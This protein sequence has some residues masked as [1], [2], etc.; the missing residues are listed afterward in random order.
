M[1]LL[2]Q[3][4]SLR[5]QNIMRP[6]VQHRQDAIT[7]QWTCRNKLCVTFTANPFLLRK[8]LKDEWGF[9]GFVVTDYTAIN[10]MVK[11]GFSADEKQAGEQALNAGVDMDM[12]SSSFSRFLK[13]SLGEGKVKQADID[14]AVRRIL[15]VKY[16]LGL[17]A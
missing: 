6:M 4:P 14:D 15:R 3:L 16:D 11:H 7:I 17:F 10:E 9:Q 12:Q 5:A 8:V 1:I 13:Q 2:I